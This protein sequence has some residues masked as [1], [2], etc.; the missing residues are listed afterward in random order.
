MCLACERLVVLSVCCVVTAVTRQ[1]LAVL[2]L[3]IV[4]F[5][6]LVLVLVHAHAHAR[7]R[8]C[9]C[10]RAR[11]RAFVSHVYSRGFVCY[12]KRDD[13]CSLFV[14][15]H[16]CLYVPLLL[17]VSCQVIWHASQMMVCGNRSGLSCVCQKR[18]STCAL[19]PPPTT[20]EL[21]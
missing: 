10:V 14:S 11:V 6:A 19:L 13:R 20:S 2:D 9:A 17:R 1:E 18:L 16:V 15:I 12:V 5:L 7:V 8:A 3:C 21:I 4:L